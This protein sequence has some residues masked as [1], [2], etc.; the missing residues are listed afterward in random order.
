MVDTVMLVEQWSHKRRANIHELRA[1]LG[2][3]FH[4]S[5]CCLPA[6]YFV[7]HVF[8]T[9]RDCP[10][11]GHVQ[12]TKEVQRDVEWLKAYLL[13]TKAVYMIHQDDRVLVSLYVD[14]C[15]IN[16]LAF[17]GTK[18]GTATLCNSLTT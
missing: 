18:A 3:L 8:T 9:P 17:K 13:C 16:V 4:V 14:A 12:L 7:N 2:K 15:S 11:T 6:R 5:Q 1:L 10:V